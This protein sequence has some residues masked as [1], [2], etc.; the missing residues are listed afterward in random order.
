VAIRDDYLSAAAAAL[1]LLREPEVAAAWDR[2]SALDLM[3]V[4]ALAAI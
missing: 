4:G 2:P 1:T 3:T